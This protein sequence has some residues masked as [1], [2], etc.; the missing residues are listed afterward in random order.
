V[1]STF[2]AAALFLVADMLRRRRG[3]ARDRLDQAAPMPQAGLLGG[4]LLVGGG[5]R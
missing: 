5:R 3:A 2:A 4:L 1:H